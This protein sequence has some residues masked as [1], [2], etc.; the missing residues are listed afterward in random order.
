[1]L[2][3]YLHSARI[4]EDTVTLRSIAHAQQVPFPLTGLQAANLGG[5]LTERKHIRG[6]CD[7]DPFPLTGLKT[8]NGSGILTQRKNSRGP[9]THARLVPLTGLKAA[10]V[11]AILTQRNKLQI[12]FTLADPFHTSARNCRSLSQ[13][14]KNTSRGTVT[15]VHL[16]PFP[17]TGLKAANVSGILTQRKKLQI[18]FTLVDPFHTSARTSEDTVTLTLSH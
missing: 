1:M 16:S 4:P 3:G 12:P 13:K 15:H 9:V 14:S 6:H 5:I 10:N 2:A 18:P 7:T 17:L 11:S 8:A